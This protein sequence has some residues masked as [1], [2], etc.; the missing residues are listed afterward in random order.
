[1]ATIHLQILMNFRNALSLTD[2]LASEYKNRHGGES[3]NKDSAKQAECAT[4]S[5][6]HRARQCVES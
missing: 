6:G 2:P 5:K 3:Q 1:M 4:I